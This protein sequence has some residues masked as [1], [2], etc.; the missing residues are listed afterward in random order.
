MS[1]CKVTSVVSDSVR[2]YG[3]QP[4]R[5]LCPWDSPGKSTGEACHALFQNIFPT[6]QSNSCLSRLL[7]WQVGS[8]PLNHQG[9]PFPGGIVL[10]FL[11]KKKKWGLPWWLSGKESACRRPGFDPW[12]RK[13]P[14]AAEQLSPCSTSTEPAPESLGAAAAE[15]QCLNDWSPRALEPTLHNERSLRRE[16]PTHPSQRQSSYSAQ[17]KSLRSTEEPAEPVNT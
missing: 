1:V 3:L 4:A 7:H 13:I 9:S 16:K 14:R 12:S 15:P 6:Q 17:V 8:L 11:K 5:L 10:N 2:P